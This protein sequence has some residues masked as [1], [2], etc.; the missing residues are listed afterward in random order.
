[1]V[2]AEA[3]SCGSLPLVARHTGLAEIA[4]GVAAEY[5][6]HQRHLTSFEPG[7]W[8]DLRARLTELLALAPDQRAQLS[9]AA[10][11]A[12]QRRWSWQGVAERI[13]AVGTGATT[14]PR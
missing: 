7:D 11:R 4:A 3:A 14:V 10:R 6:S 2:A 5:P 9:A 8:E 1:M 13:L 12:V